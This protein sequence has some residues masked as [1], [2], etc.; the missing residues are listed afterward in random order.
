MRSDFEKALFKYKDGP[1]N[2]L[3]GA[4]I[5]K[6]PP[7]NAP[8]WNEMQT[9]FVMQL[10]DKMETQ[11]WPAASEFNRHRSEIKNFQIRPETFWGQMHDL[12]GPEIIQT[13]LMGVQ[14]GTPNK[15]HSAIANLLESGFFKCAVTT[16]FDEYV[17]Q[18]LS[19]KVQVV[20]KPDRFEETFSLK[21]SKYIKLHGTLSSP[22]SLSYTLEH[23]DKLEEQNIPILYEA[24][25]GLP[26]I[27]AGYSG[28]DSDVLPTLERMKEELPLVIVV[29]HPG[30]NAAQPVLRVAEGNDKWLIVETTCSDMFSVLIGSDNKTI[31]TCTQEVMEG[32]KKDAYKLAVERIPLP[33][34]AA[35]LM[36]VYDLVGHQGGVLTYALLAHDA[37]VD[38]RYSS[39]LSIAESIDLNILLGTALAKCGHPIFKAMFSEAES[40]A[41]RDSRVSDYV[42][43]SM[44]RQ[45]ATSR[46][47]Y[48]HEN[49][50][51][52]NTKISTKK[53]IHSSPI[54]LEGMMTEKSRF[55]HLW[56]IGL[57]KRRLMQCDDAMNAFDGALEI[58]LQ[59]SE[60]NIL[61]HLE[62]GRFLLDLAGAMTVKGELDHDEEVLANAIKYLGFAEQ[63]SRKAHDW[64]THARAF[65][66]LSRRFLEWN[67]EHIENIEQAMRYA[68]LAKESANKTKNT[69]L[70]KRIEDHILNII[71]TMKSKE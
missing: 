63:E 56:D 28:Y 42:R 13:A 31:D 35:A 68:E 50:K 51:D 12:V 67:T 1:I 65:L 71:G 45:S 40:L 20:I 41:E 2:I 37:A 46:Y 16:N 61:T 38:P 49:E 60:K 59:N 17:E 3:F 53:V 15:N 9:A 34:C 52:V 4:G 64:K 22:I 36:L 6:D 69:E 8:I 29:K 32:D 43:I 25:S 62:Q 19:D 5:S 14:S 21:G 58:L 66:D 30:A 26:L 57:Q 10:F 7:A 11:G 23:Y 55:M 54:N 24:L 48:L 33:I 27:I 18:M 70:I 39:S 47:T 44:A